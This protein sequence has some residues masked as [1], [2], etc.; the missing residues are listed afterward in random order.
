[1]NDLLY[2]EKLRLRLDCV[3]FALKALEDFNRF[4]D[5]HEVTV[6]IDGLRLSVGCVAEALDSVAEDI[7]SSK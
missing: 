7:L 6:Q 2:I 1:M 5:E 3:R 4:H